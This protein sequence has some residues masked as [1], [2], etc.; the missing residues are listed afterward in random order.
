M[1][2]EERVDISGKY[3]KEKTHSCALGKHSYVFLWEQF[4]V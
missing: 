2:S 3:K 4:R 1:N